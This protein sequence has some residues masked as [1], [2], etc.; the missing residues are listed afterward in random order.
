[1]ERLVTVEEV[2]K[3]VEKI[4]FNYV[5]DRALTLHRGDWYLRVVVGF[6]I[7]ENNSTEY[8]VW[9]LNAAREEP[10]LYEGYYTDN[11]QDAEEKY[12]N[13]Q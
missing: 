12:R 9:L 11:K 7:R 13:K 1:M 5:A 4:G 10:A 3:A 8:A 6:K 2:R